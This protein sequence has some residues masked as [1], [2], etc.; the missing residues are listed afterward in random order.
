[1]TEAP[2][3]PRAGRLARPTWLDT[4]LVLGVLLVLVSVVVGARVLAAADRSQLVWVTGSDLAAGVTLTDDD[5]VAAQVRLFGSGAGYLP[6]HGEKPV[7]YVLGRAVGSGELL[8]RSALVAPGG[9][10]EL[11]Q[12]SVP[13]LPVH[14][15]SGLGRGERV[16]VWTTP[17]RDS[18]PTAEEAAVTGSRLVLPALTVQQPVGDA[19]ALG[20]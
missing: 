1:V 17:T 7:G 14:Y 9:G 12:V 8:A 5:L 18:G 13:V 16:D 20:A 11:R 10:D 19:G 6:A 15:P 4:R 3:S 2:G